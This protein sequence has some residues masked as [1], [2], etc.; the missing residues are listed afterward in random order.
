MSFRVLIVDDSH[1][2]RAFIRRTL[3]ASGFEAGDYF[4]ASDGIEAL[5]L[6][7]REW[8]D[9]ILTDINMP[10]L[11]GEEFVRKL[12]ANGLTKALPIIVVSTD[13][14]ATRMDHL[15]ELGVRGYLIKPFTPEALR[16]QVEHAL[17]VQHA[18]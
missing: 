8:V 6:L 18:G 17:E 14:T 15:R 4:E 13:A 1:A 5:D 9:I 7:D 12:A 3:E 16:E 2:M 11:N 10:R